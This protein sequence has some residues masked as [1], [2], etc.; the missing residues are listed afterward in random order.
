LSIADRQRPAA[1]IRR[2][3]L[4]SHPRR[5][6]QVSVEVSSCYRRGTCG[7]NADAPARSPTSTW[8]RRRPFSGHVDRALLGPRA[9]AVDAV[10]GGDLSRSSPPSPPGKVPGSRRTR[11]R[12][13]RPSWPVPYSLVDDHRDPSVR[14]R[15]R[16]PDRRR[17]R[18]MTPRHRIRWCP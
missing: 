7:T 12:R 18:R 1:D 11:G 2:S 6:P 9:V 15:R 3:G 10:V 14:G 4:V 8:A 17:R 13:P 16:R 5:V